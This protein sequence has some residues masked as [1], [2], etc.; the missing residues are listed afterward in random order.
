MNIYIVRHGETDCNKN[1]IC[2]GWYDY[3]IN[4]RGIKQAE[5]LGRFFSN[6]KIDKIISSSLMRAKMTAEIINNSL[7]VPIEFDNSIREIYFGDWENIPIAD[8]HRLDPINTRLWHDDCAKAN[9][10]GG[11]QF[12]TFYS[13]VAYGFDRIV[14]ENRSNDILI[15]SHSGAISIILSHITGAGAKGFWRFRTIHECYT[16]LVS[17]SSS[18]YIER[19]N[20]PIGL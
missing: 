9:I 12:N 18:F 20:I 16:K 5:N 3:P 14:S 7:N 6:I 13:R 8:M 10:P 1:N 2:Y 17:D 15:V 11:E 19:I 4:E